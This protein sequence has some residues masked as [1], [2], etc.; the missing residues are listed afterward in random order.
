MGREIISI[1]D[2][3]AERIGP[4][5]VLIGMPFIYAMIIPLIFLD[6]CLEAYHHFCFPLYGIPV[7]PRSRYIRIDRHRLKYL[8]GISKLNCL[9]CGYGNGLM[10]Y[11]SVIAA[12]TELYWCPIQHKAG[13]DFSSP[14][15]HHLFAKYGEVESLQKLLAKDRTNLQMI[16][17]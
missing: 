13:E 1:E 10:H 6:I 8:S 17:E 4:A 2:S 9:Y 12:M 5:R 16:G 15:H 3:V 11:A 7:V 14:R